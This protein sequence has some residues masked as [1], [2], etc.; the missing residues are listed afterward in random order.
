MAEKHTY[1]LNIETSTA[2]C[3][4][5]ISSESTI[6]AFR[7]SMVEKSHATV[8]TPF[9]EDIMKETG[10]KYGD[11]SALAVSR[12]PGSYTGLR[13]GVSVAK[14]IC[15]GAGLPLIAVDTLGIMAGK[16]LSLAH[17]GQKESPATAAAAAQVPEEAFS[18]LRGA[19]SSNVLLCPMIDARRMEVYTALYDTSGKRVREISAEIIDPSSF[20]EVPEKKSI[21]FFG[22][23]AEKCRDVA[24][25]KNTLFIPG[26]YPSAGDMAHM[27]LLAFREGRFED[28]AYFEPFY[29]K[30]FIAT[31]PKNKTKKI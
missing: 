19:D 17:R 30:D 27:S 12:G 1:I 21:L 2:V 26:I 20:S 7:E 22:D 11:L 16:V 14:G 31:T 24:A 8:L 18:W 3:S 28:T 10:K 4:V 15:Y 25:R 29:L 5:S 13:I 6:L 9:I 23:G